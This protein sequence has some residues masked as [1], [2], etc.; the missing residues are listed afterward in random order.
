MVRAVE[1]AAQRA[2]FK[3]LR[4]LMAKEFTYDFGGDPSPDEAIEEWRRDRKYLRALARVLRMGCHA[5]DA[6][7]VDC[8][9]KGDTSFRA[10]FKKEEPGWRLKYFVQG[11]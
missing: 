4:S 8:P 11:D 10:G 2:D 9:G 7:T 6:Q 1:K 5:T 3:K